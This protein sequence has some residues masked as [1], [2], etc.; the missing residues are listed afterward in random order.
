LA[1]ADEID[2]IILTP[3]LR[4]YVPP[5]GMELNED[6][7]QAIRKMYHRG[8]DPYPVAVLIRAWDKVTRTHYGWEWPTLQEIT[9]ECNRLVA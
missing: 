6:R 7:L 9:L 5:K 2:E 3:L 4:S 8:L 1:S